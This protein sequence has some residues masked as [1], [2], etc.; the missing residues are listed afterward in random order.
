MA[1]TSVSAF[2]ARKADTAHTSGTFS[3]RKTNSRAVG[4]REKLRMI[5]GGR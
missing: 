5:T 1:T 3:P 4:N 2:T